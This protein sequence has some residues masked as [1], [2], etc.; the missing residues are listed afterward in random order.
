MVARKQEKANQSRGFWGN[1]SSPGF[2]P[3]FLFLFFP[4]EGGR[5]GVGREQA[6]YFWEPKRESV[7]V[8]WGW[9]RK[10]GAGNDMEGEQ[11][12]MFWLYHYNYL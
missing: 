6:F 1:S 8:G 2:L 12:K 9:S 7:E 10:T 3:S 4:G 11:G 5:V